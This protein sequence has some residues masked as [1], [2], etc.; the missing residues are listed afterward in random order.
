MIVSDARLGFHQYS[1]SKSGLIDSSHSR[2]ADLVAKRQ[3]QATDRR[4]FA[5][6]GVSE[7]FL[8]K[9]FDARFD[10]MWYPSLEELLDS[11]VIHQVID[12]QKVE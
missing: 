8:D 7:E 5:E 2:I 1:L 9:M 3:E 12:V 10:D 4:L 11:N 6:Q